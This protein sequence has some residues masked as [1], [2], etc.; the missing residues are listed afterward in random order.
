MW[1]GTNPTKVFC[2][3][4]QKIIQHD[5][6]IHTHFFARVTNKLSWYDKKIL[7]CYTKEAEKNFILKMHHCKGVIKKSESV[8]LM[9]GTNDNS[10]Y[11]WKRRSTKL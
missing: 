4:K 1:V 10:P 9:Y 11:V 2:N 5:W 6:N 8:G 7:K 3:Q